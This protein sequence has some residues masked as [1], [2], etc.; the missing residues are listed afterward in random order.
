MSLPTVL[1]P[2]DPAEVIGIAEAAR[3]ARKTE[4]TLRNWCADHR[5]GHRAAGQWA[6][7]AIALDMLLAGDCAALEAHL[8]GDR[9]SDVV[10]AYYHHR[11][12]PLTGA[13]PTSATKLLAES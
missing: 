10:H 9:T 2:Y 1:R 7:S 6:V 8:A 3:R 11:A 12:I 5:I 4:R 13:R